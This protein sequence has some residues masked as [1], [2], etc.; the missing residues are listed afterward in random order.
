MSK[1]IV[2]T[3]R[4]RNP[5]VA[6]ARFRQAGR[7]A[8]GDRAARRQGRDALKREI[9]QLGLPRDDHRGRAGP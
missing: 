3:A 5:L 4:P 6:A 8:S 9:A 7:H 2:P 1:L